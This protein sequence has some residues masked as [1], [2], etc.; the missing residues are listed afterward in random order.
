MSQHI[1]YLYVSL[2]LFSLSLFFIDFKLMLNDA[3]FERL[4]FFSSQN[5]GSI[6]LSRFDRFLIVDQSVNTSVCVFAV[7][8]SSH[9]QADA[10]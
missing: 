1:E 9:A 10:I 5:V 3:L 8:L 7:H 4:I 2:L 6:D